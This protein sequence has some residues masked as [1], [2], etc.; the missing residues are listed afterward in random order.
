MKMSET[1][2]HQAIQTDLT[3]KQFERFVLP[4]LP[5]QTEIQRTQA[6]TTRRNGLVPCITDQ[7]TPVY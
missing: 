1:K 2:L 4:Y 7:E 6:A 5:M 3:L